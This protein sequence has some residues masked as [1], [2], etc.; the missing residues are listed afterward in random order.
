MQWMGRGQATFIKKRFRVKAP[1]N[2]LQKSLLQLVCKQLR[3]HVCGL[4]RMLLHQPYMGHGS[5]CLP[6]TPCF[7]GS[8][9][10][11]WGCT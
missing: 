5:P 2:V 1:L 10:M 6:S 11:L 3:E 9:G 7:R 4:F 8:F